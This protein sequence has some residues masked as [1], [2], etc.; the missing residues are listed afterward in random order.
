VDGSDMP[1]LYRVGLEDGQPPVLVQ[2]GPVSSIQ[3]VSRDGRLVAYSTTLDEQTGFEDMRYSATDGGTQ[4]IVLRSTT[5]TFRLGRMFTPDS[6]FVVYLGGS[7]K[8]YNGPLLVQPT[9]G[10]D[11]IKLSELSYSYANLDGDRLVYSDHLIEAPADATGYAYGTTDVMLVDLAAGAT[12]PTKL[13]GGVD[14]L[15]STTADNATLVYA[16]RGDAAR[17]GI[18]TMP[19]P[20]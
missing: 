2:A 6:K 12:A 13:I 14:A 3:E 10:G 20:K 19:I 17:A 18:Y 15:F 4:P 7:D 9:A 11:A 5:D 8:D 16:R 1:S